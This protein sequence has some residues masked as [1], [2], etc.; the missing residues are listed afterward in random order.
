MCGLASARAVRRRRVSRSRRPAALAARRRVSTTRAHA[1]VRSPPARKGRGSPLAPSTAHAPLLAEMRKT[2]SSVC[3]LY[4][5]STM[6]RLWPWHTSGDW[7]GLAAIAAPRRNDR[8]ELLSQLQLLLLRQRLARPDVRSAHAGLPPPSPPPLEAAARLAP[9]RA[10]RECHA[11]RGR[12]VGYPRYLGF[13]RGSCL[14]AL[15]VTTFLPRNASR[16]V[17]AVPRRAWPSPPCRAST[18]GSSRSRRTR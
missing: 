12:F 6:G 14:F 2:P 4:A 15:L 8:G 7:Y 3:A 1:G 10:F 13:R 11:C 17:A 18:A 9:A 5:S 16:A